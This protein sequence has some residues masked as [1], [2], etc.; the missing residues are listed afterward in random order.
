MRML[1]YLYRAFLTGLSA[2][3]LASVP[4]EATTFTV[5]STA[6]PGN[7]VCTPATT[8]DGC[9]LREAIVAANG[10]SGDDTIIFAPGI[11]GTIQL[12]GPLPDLS[13]NIAL[14]GPGAGLLTVRRDTGGD[15][16]IFNI[17]NGSA[18]GPTISI[19]GMTISNGR[20]TQGLIAGSGIFNDHSKLTINS[21]TVS[22]NSQGGIFTGADGGS[23]SLTATNCVVT[24][25]SSP[26]TVSASNGG[27]A[28][29]VVSGCTVNNNTSGF[30]L[31]A[32]NGNISG[33]VSYSTFSGNS[34]I[35]LANS[36][37][38]NGTANLAVNNCTSTGNTAFR[39]AGITNF[40]QNGGVATLTLQ[41][42][43][44][45]NN[46]ATID[47]AGGFYN[48]A[49]AA[50]ANAIVK[51]CTFSGNSGPVGAISN[52]AVAGSMCSIQIGNTIL[53][54]GTSGVNLGNE[55]DATSTVTFTSLGYNLSSDSGG[56]ILSQSGD[57]IN[58]DPKLDPGGLKN[59]GGPTQ[60]IALQPGSP[61]IDKGKS[62]GITTD[63]RGQPRPFDNTAVAPASGGDDSDIGAFETNTG[64]QPG[65]SL[66]VTTTND[67]NDGGCSPTDCTLREA[68]IAAGNLF[69]DNTIGFA[70]GVTGTIQLSG[71]L[72][73]LSTN[74][75]I[76]GPGALVLT[77][78]RNVGGDYRIFTVTNGTN[79]GP[80]VTINGLT[81]SNGK[82]PPPSPLN[83]GA[84]LNDR[85]TLTLSNCVL[86]G[87]TATNG[88]AIDNG[89]TNG[90]IS[91]ITLSNCTLTANNGNFGGTIFNT[92]FGGSATVKLTN[93]TLTDN[94][95][96]RG[97]AVHTTSAGGVASLQVTNCT[98]NNNAATFGGIF[99]DGTSGNASVTFANT[100]L[101]AAPSSPNIFNSNNAA[102]VFSF[103]HNL[104]SDNGS[105]FLT[106]TG[107]QI[108]TDP[109]FDPAGLANNGGF[110][111]TIALQAGS[112]AINT[113][114]D[115]NAPSTDQ[116]GFHR[117]G[118]SDIGAFE[119]G[120][121]TP[122]TLANI[123]TRLRVETG[124]NVLIGGFIVTGTQNKK[125]I[126]RAIGPSLPFADKLANPTLELFGPAGLIESN[127]NW[128]DSPNKQA[129]IDSTIPPTD[130]LESAIVAT[131]P[132]NGTGY[133]AIVRGASNGTGTGVVEAYDLDRSVDSMLANISTRGLVQTG[134][135][136]LIA[137]TILL[138][139][140]PQ[141]VMVRAI[142]PSLPIPGALADPTLELRDQNG[143]LFAANNNWRTSQE[144]EI[145]ATTIAPTND[146]E[147]AIVATLPANNAQYTAI[148]RGVNNTTG[149][150][151]VEVYAL[152]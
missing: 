73:D 58:T 15:Y 38:N 120:G 36:A 27:T 9:T 110:T 10:N 97:A 121:L 1:V 31:S 76:Q 60:T 69:G 77:V 129:I 71:A 8:G 122:S 139:Q 55:V 26:L 2:L 86:T 68:I 141:K 19:S 146:L 116:R 108:N 59:N 47:H 80:T 14:Q 131:L 143:G 74:M 70:P 119:F 16:R 56:G 117:A 106:G 54:A 52:D 125:V 130:N 126:I 104:S 103:G 99:V 13:T 32:N 64:L 82:A 85:A 112:T 5:T 124:D 107:D 63:Q 89:G 62:L 127:D 94:T 132:A 7:G 6:D 105:G 49:G 34:N 44:I 37:N 41:N 90:G 24:N 150:A 50:T 29:V 25:N 40:A 12:T 100:I 84:I 53:Q 22:G 102:S 75:S 128:M 109:K 4:A 88:G 142:G 92:G 30:S 3:V 115:A 93:C 111:P 145:I 118:V 136:V 147:S 48:S 35:A 137:G 79:N 66:T 95:A 113:G 46:T 11:T 83:G 152:Q 72:P 144:A 140:T 81:L 33:T 78:R 135:N 114:G 51:S 148:V 28:N 149:I 87:N 123:S 57:Q 98:L 91:T 23:A 45:S 96:S 61:A 17:S 42:S 67:H 134:D 101:K 138:G 18:S 43:T 151:V 65:P 21:C 133:T 20:V 39:G